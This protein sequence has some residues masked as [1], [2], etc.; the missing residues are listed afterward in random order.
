MSAN[1]FTPPPRASPW[2]WAQTALL[3]VNLAWTTLANGGY[4]PRISLVTTLLTSALVALHV[5]AFYRPGWQRPAIHPAGW[6]VLPF[7]AYALANVLWVTPVRWLGWSDWLGWAQMIAVFWVTLNGISS[8]GPRRVIFFLLVALAMVG[9]LFGSYQTFVQPDWRLF[10]G[11]RLSDFLGRAS[12]PFGVPN[13]F[14]G[15][16]LLVFPAVVALALRRA[17]SLNQRIWWGWVGLVLLFGLGLTLSRGAWL[18]LLVAL[19]V[20]AWLSEPGGWRKRASFASALFALLIAA[21]AFAIDRYPAARERFSQLVMNGGERSRP[22]MW[23]AAWKLF[24]D[25]P[26]LG[27]GAGS[28]NVLFERHRE[29]KFQDEPMWA[30]NEY[31]NTLSDYGVVGFLLFFGAIGVVIVRC[32]F[33]PRTANRTHH[34]L[35]DP[36]V[37]A[38]FATG[39][40]AFALQ[41]ALD[42]HLKI[43]ALAFACAVVG[44]LAVGA[45]WPSAVLS[46][47][48]VSRSRGLSALVAVVVVAGG[49]LFF[50]PRLLAEAMRLE[51]RQSI[52]RL[53]GIDPKDPKYAQ[54][55]PGAVAELRQATRRDPANGQAWAD[56]AYATSLLGF[57]EPERRSE[58]GREAEAAAERALQLSTQSGEFWIRRGAA[59]NL[60]G[61]WEAAGTDYEKAVNLASANWVSWY[62]YAEHFTRL[63]ASQEA[64][65]GALEFCLRLDPGNRAALA[66]RQQLAIKPGAP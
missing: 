61:R 29:E 31:L 26:L 10:G 3:G 57:V 45:L 34:G 65:L 54:V 51:A 60:Q 4:G 18:A 59:R 49:L 46:S 7:L 39:L 32:A 43:P 6:M 53:W 63:P 19:P 64:A 42:F 12:G 40:L 15:F 11:P 17:A 9:V 66:L 27:T 22:F 30:H 8:R 20:W 62:H 55:V 24:C 48:P 28:Y 23:R 33:P 41:M 1:S 21:G 50:A 36:P 58:I 52:D 25:A 14:A 44:A 5:I 56:L 35:T 38:G 47:P 2:E 37:V 16:L 13:S